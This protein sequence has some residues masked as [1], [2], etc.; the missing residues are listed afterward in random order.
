[1]CGL[2]GGFR[3]LKTGGEGRGLGT[4]LGLRTSAYV[5]RCFLASKD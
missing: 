4:S 2:R 1:M 3:G 5:L